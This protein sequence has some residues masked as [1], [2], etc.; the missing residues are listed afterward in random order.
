MDIEIMKS[1]IA[2]IPQTYNEKILETIKNLLMIEDKVDFWDQLP[3]EDQEAT[4]E[5]IR[6]LDEGKSI[7]IEK[8]KFMMK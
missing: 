7:S 5:G 4:N 3:L 2:A 6:Q 1:L 8:V